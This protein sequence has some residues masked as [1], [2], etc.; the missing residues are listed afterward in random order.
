M[1]AALR[2]VQKLLTCSILQHRELSR[3]PRILGILGIRPLAASGW[4]HLPP[5]SRFVAAASG[6]GSDYKDSQFPELA[7]RA[8]YDST[9]HMTYSK[10]NCDLICAKLPNE[11]RGFFPNLLCN[12]IP[13]DIFRPSE[14]LRHA[15]C[16]LPRGHFVRPEPQT[17]L[18]ASLLPK[19]S[20]TVYLGHRTSARDLGMPSRL[21]F[22]QELIVPAAT[23]PSRSLCR[24]EG[25]LGWSRVPAGEALHK[26]QKSTAP[27]TKAVLSRQRK[28]DPSSPEASFADV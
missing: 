27:S 21:R 1:R 10:H 15:Q 28:A 17:R 25:F 4:V 18:V 26:P 11:S 3:D 2:S 20:V 22:T 13:S 6:P 14:C 8:R 7:K 23:C 16:G 12:P 9:V 19:S 24:C 5:R